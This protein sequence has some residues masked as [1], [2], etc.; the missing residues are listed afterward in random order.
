MY[1]I[2][3][4]LDFYGSEF[5]DVEAITARSPFG[6]YNGIFILRGRLRCN[7]KFPHNI[8]ENIFQVPVPHPPNM[9]TP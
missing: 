2:G 4:N 3:S 8:L 5:V 1:G 7:E 9:N 6:D